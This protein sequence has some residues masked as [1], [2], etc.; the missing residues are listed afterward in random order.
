MDAA[1]EMKK[2]IADRKT[3]QV[4]SLKRLDYAVQESRATRQ[5]RRE[6]QRQTG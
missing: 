2:I 3:S 4:N 1:A 5:K 6:E